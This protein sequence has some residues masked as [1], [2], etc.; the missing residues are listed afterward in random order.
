MSFL[1]GKRCAFFARKRGCA[2]QDNQQLEPD[3]WRSNVGGTVR[4]VDMLKGELP[5]KDFSLSG[6]CVLAVDQAVAAGTA[7]MAAMVAA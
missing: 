3:G 7:S 5:P 4:R 6:N 2:E 1:T